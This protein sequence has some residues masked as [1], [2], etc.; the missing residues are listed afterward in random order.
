MQFKEVIYN[1][2]VR[3]HTRQLYGTDTLD[4]IRLHFPVWKYYFGRLL[5]LDKNAR[6]LDVGCGNGSFVYYLQ[7]T[8]YLH[9]EGIDLSGEQIAYGR[10]LGISSIQKADIKIFLEEKKEE[11]DCI[12][13]FDVLEHFTRQE[14]FDILTAVCAALKPGGCFIL[15]SP[16]GEGLFHSGVFYGDFTHEIA[17]TESSL[18]QICLNT[19]FS[20]VTCFPTGPVPKGI[21]SA[22]RWLLWQ[23]IVLKMRLYKMAETGSGKGIFTQ[24]LIAKAIKG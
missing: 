21:V 17:F 5:P 19:G 2:Y 16:N 15:Q 8:G 13:A 12:T 11:Y 14:I 10:S 4:S 24:N 1:N 9:A 23:L 18:R 20:T 22:A 6:I 7:Q 3:N